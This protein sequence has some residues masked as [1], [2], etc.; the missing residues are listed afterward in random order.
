MLQHSRTA[1]MLAFAIAAIAGYVDAVGF[2]GSGAFF[3][4]FMS[5]NTTRLG[6]G[7][8]GDGSAA[9]I[10]AGLIACFVAGVTVTSLL[11]RRM[12]E[13]R[14]PGL[15]L[16]FCAGLLTV[17][18][19]ALGV[20]ASIAPFMLLAFAMGGINLA[21]ENEGEVRFGL[22]YMTGTLIKL[23]TRL[24]DALAGE[25]RADW[26]PLLLL[27][28]ALSGGAIL[29]GVAYEALAMNALWPAV[30][31]VWVLAGFSLLTRKA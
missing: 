18:T 4:S 30:A 28:L 9:A 25:P 16:A 15:T 23:G 3:V 22:T 21:L 31:G 1:R 24:A 6:V 5:G 10:A 11:R 26:L 8:A 12:A 13:A 27:W 29:G 2:L 20:S 17:A 14:K 19:L 7:I